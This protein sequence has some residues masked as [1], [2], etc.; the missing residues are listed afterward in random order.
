LTEE[1]WQIFSIIRG[2]LEP[3]SQMTTMLSSA[4]VTVGYVK[5]WIKLVLPHVQ[6]LANLTAEDVSSEANLIKS[7]GTKMLDKF[8]KYREVYSTYEVFACHLLDPRFKLLT[9]RQ[10]FGE[11]LTRQHMEVLKDEIAG[12]SA[13]SPPA[14]PNVRSSTFNDILQSMIPTQPHFLSELDQYNSMPA[15]PVTQDPFGWWSVN[16]KMFPTLSK[17]A[18]RYMTMQ[19]TSVESERLFSIAGHVISRRRTRLSVMTVR[20]LLCLR[21]WS[22]FFKYNASKPP[23]VTENYEEA[24]FD[25]EPWEYS[26]DGELSE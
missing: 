16:A 13:G 21:S 22:T 4:T 1:D 12:I 23:T 25:P 7:M 2:C 15:V 5:A 18:Q 10:F 14:T 26:T 11:E 8:D 24:E 17:L 19:A 20:Q 3:F 9:A 6:R